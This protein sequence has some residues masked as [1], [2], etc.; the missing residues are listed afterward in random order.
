MRGLLL[1]DGGRR[2]FLP[3]VLVLF[4]CGCV[5]MFAFGATWVGSWKMALD[6]ATGG[7][8][9]LGAASAGL[10]A[11]TY[12]RMRAEAWDRLT[13]GSARG[14]RGWIA[15]LLGICTAALVALGGCVLL[16]TTMA[17]LAGSRA[18][19]ITLGMTVQPASALICLTVLGA[20]LGSLMNGWA[21]APLA[22]AGALLLAVLSDTG[23]LPG[24]FRT[25]GVT[26]ALQAQTFDRGVLGWQSAVLISVA[27]LLLLVL[28]SHTV[29][30]VRRP[31]LLGLAVLPLL[32]AVVG[33][34]ELGT[35]GHERYRIQA[36]TPALT[37][38]GAR[39]RVCLSVDTT[40]PLDALAAE[41]HRQAGPLTAVGAVVPETF[42]QL[43]FTPVPAGTGLILLTRDEQLSRT[44]APSSA[45]LSLAIPRDCPAYSAGRP[46]ERALAVRGVLVDWIGSRNGVRATLSDGSPAER[47][48]LGL[49]VAEQAAWVRDT[50][51]KL[52]ACELTTL[53]LPYRR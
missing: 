26:G 3:R 20:T 15:P 31:V 10:A 22:A 37:C 9:L 36:G 16:A 30:G 12:A 38:A 23:L 40:R 13:A 52:S 35:R 21:A 25:G 48:W 42:Q 18:A 17:S 27:G 53:T 28:A 34:H 32:I 29:P 1:W 45:S 8:F 11:W 19:P 47:A 50:Y 14:L 49:P 4:T 33:W 43:L 39:P 44:P 5:V 41:L 51:R 7:V 6:Q 24:L 46:P 2:W